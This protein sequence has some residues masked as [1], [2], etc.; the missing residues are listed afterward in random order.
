MQHSLQQ[1]LRRSRRR[2]CCLPGYIGV[3]RVSQAEYTHTHTTHTHITEFSK[4]RGIGRTD[5]DT[6][7]ARYREPISPR[8]IWRRLAARS[9]DWVLCSSHHTTSDSLSL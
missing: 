7:L 8:S 1:S 6:V 3:I 4:R 2:W 5:D 9:N